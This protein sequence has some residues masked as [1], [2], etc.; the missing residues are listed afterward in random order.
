MGTLIV[1]IEH[2]VNENWVGTRILTGADRFCCG[3]IHNN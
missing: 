3:I 2:L 1:I